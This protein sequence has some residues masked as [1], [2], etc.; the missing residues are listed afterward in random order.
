MKNGHQCKQTVESIDDNN[1]V[2]N[3]HFGSSSKYLHA[4]SLM[5]GQF[6]VSFGALEV[7][8]DQVTLCPEGAEIYVDCSLGS[9]ALFIPKTWR[10]VD[11]LHT[12]LGAVENDIRIADLGE[13][14]PKLTISG[15]V[16]LGNI[17]IRYI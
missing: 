16:H 1:P 2:V 10:V 14:A 5:G 17:D 15:N 7:Y 12:S 6:T 4:D 8:F 11:N 13:N 3:V 9:L